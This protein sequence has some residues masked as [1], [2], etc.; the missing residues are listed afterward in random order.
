MTWNL[1]AY[2]QANC[3]LYRQGQE[4]SVIVH[5]IICENTQDE[6]VIQ[7]LQ[8]KEVTQKSLLEALKRYLERSGA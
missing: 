8:Q 1:E 7:A 3:R 4:H 5:H 6:R 2:Q